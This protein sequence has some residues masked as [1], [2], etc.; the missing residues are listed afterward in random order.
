[1]RV[2]R[3][4]PFDANVEIGQSA[5]PSKWDIKDEFKRRVENE[6]EEN[7][8]KD[9]FPSRSKCLFVCFS[10]GKCR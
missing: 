4:V 5:V 2:Y 9:R 7:R 8:P 3:I 1:M 6:L 10:K